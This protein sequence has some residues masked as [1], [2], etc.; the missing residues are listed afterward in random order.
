MKVTSKAVVN[1]FADFLSKELKPQ[2]PTNTLGGFMM[3]FSSGLIRQRAATVANK[4]ISNPLISAVIIDEEGM[5][6]LDDLVE[7]AQGAIAD[8][9]LT[10][11]IPLAG[12]ITFHKSDA[13]VIKQYIERSP[14]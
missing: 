13:D 2:Y 11:T 12:D 9:G 10:I 6:D 8:T 4:L 7:A 14:Q 3:G 1:G 5:I